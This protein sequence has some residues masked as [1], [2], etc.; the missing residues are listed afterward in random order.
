[1]LGPAA[2]RRSDGTGKGKREQRDDRKSQNEDNHG[3]SHGLGWQAN[4]QTS[5]FIFSSL[6]EG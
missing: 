1:M 6:E 5:P 2:G 4:G 3:R